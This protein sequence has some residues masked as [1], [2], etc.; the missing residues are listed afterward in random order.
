MG[1]LDALTLGVVSASLTGL[2]TLLTLLIKSYTD[3]RQHKWDMAAKAIKDEEDRKERVDVARAQASSMTQLHEGIKQTVELA[4]AGVA[5]AKSAYEEANT[6]NIKIAKVN[7]VIMD[8]GNVIIKM[9]AQFNLLVERLST[10]PAA[11]TGIQPLDVAGTPIHNALEAEL[12]AAT[13]SASALVAEAKAADAKI[14]PETNT[15][16]P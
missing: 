4:G 7:A 15:T 14:A 1:Q 6:V 9:A 12:H 8:Q 11:N 13:A 5:Q 16:T 2:F 10:M 3:S